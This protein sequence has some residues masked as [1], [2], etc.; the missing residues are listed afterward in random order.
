MASTWTG[1]GGRADKCDLQGPNPDGNYERNVN[2]GRIVGGLSKDAGAAT[3]TWYNSGGGFQCRQAA[4]A[5]RSGI[6]KTRSGMGRM[7][8]GEGGLDQDRAAEMVVLIKVLEKM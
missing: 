5:G 6:A 7:D 8:C 4:C 2:A 1:L 3:T